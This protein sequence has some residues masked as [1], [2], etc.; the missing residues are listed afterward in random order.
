LRGGGVDKVVVCTSLE[1]ESTDYLALCG[2]RL[3]FQEKVIFEMAKMMQNPVIDFAKM[4]ENDN[5][6]DGIR[7]YKDELD[8]EVIEQAVEEITARNSKSLLEEGFRHHD[9][10]SVH[11][12]NIFT[13]SRLP[14][15]YGSCRHEVII[16]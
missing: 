15:E 16:I 14:L 3:V 5:L 12:R 2:T 10:S 11:G 8:F 6:E 13:F 1:A 9:F 4:D 7:V